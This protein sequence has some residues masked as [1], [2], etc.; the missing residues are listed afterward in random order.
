MCGRAWRRMLRS[1]NSA[2]SKE[3]PVFAQTYPTLEA[4]YAADPRRRYSRERDVGLLWCDSG[5][6][7]FR[8]AWVQGTREVYLF[9][10]ERI[11][12][13]GGT[14]ELLERRFGERDL[15]R[16]FAGYSEVCARSGSLQWFLERAGVRRAVPTAA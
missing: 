6:A 13:S 9:M 4:F 15:A 16:T 11:D 5:T 3:R 14:V 7:T 8:A 2:D 1:M 12:G 10:Y